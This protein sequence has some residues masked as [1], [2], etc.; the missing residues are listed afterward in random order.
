MG[1]VW[2]H[3]HEVWVRLWHHP[4]CQLPR[5]LN[6]NCPFKV[7]KCFLHTFKLFKSVSFSSFSGDAWKLVDND[8]LFSSFL[9]PGFA[10]LAFRYSPFF[11][12]NSIA[13]ALF[14]NVLGSSTSSSTFTP[15]FTEFFLFPN[16]NSDPNLILAS[17]VEAA[18]LS[19]RFRTIACSFFPLGI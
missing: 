4:R 18:L 2:L 14:L 11:V 12:L 6:L 8:P 19:P 13:H 15:P 9:S 3:S 5:S 7:N 1:R 10:V 16:L 17:T